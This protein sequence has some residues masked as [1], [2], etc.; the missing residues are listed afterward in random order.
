MKNI[1]LK[2]EYSQSELP[3]IPKDV[4]EIINC[5]KKENLRTEVF[6]KL[7]KSKETF[8][9]KIKEIRYFQNDLPEIESLLEKDIDWEKYYYDQATQ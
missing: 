4:E 5:E 3:T 8:I 6:C 7:D 2:G 9:N 1:L